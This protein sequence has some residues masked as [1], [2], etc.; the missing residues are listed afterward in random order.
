MSSECADDN[1]LVLGALVG[2][3]LTN[4]CYVY[5]GCCIVAGAPEAEQS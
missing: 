3:G 1:F 5:C 4:P 2:L